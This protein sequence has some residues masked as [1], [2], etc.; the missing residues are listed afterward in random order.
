MSSQALE[1]LIDYKKQIEKDYKVSYLKFN[2]KN[3]MKKK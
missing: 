2:L 1:D 3:R